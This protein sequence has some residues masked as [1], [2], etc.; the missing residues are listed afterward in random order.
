MH[1]LTLLLAFFTL[2]LLTTQTPISKF[3]SARVPSKA[4]SKLFPHIRR[5]RKADILIVNNKSG[6]CDLKIVNMFKCDAT[7]TIDKTRGLDGEDKGW[8]GGE[9]S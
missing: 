4:K 9:V 5:P 8:G 7:V 1:L 6:G 2:L 3:P